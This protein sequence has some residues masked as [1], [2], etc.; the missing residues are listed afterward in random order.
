MAVFYT[1]SEFYTL[2]NAKNTFPLSVSKTGTIAIQATFTRVIG[3]GTLFTKELEVGGWIYVP[4]QNEFRKITGIDTNT[5]MSIDKPFSAVVNAGTA[6]LY[7]APTVY[8][9]I[10]VVIPPGLADGAINTQLL[11]NGIPVNWSKASRDNSGDRDLIDPVLLDATGTVM[12]II[13]VKP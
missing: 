7:I 12:H 9:E 3:T 4:A 10:G 8:C 6:L 5:E 2:S 1:N 11:T 13:G